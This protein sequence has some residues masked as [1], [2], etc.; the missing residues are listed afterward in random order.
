MAFYLN[1]IK[2]NELKKSTSSNCNHV[3]VWNQAEL[4]AEKTNF[5]DKLIQPSGE[6]YCNFRILIVN[7]D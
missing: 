4:K 2:K 5:E 7:N 6:I 1:G 3:L